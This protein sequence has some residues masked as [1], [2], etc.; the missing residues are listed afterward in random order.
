MEIFTN[1]IE[2][3]TGQFMENMVYYKKLLNKPDEIPEQKQTRRKAERKVT[4]LRSKGYD[5]RIAKSRS[6]VF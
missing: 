3:S 4:G 1:K 2:A 5:S 6:I